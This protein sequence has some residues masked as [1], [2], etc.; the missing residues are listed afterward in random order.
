MDAVGN[1]SLHLVTSVGLQSD[2][3]N[4]NPFEPPQKNK[5]QANPYLLAGN[6]GGKSEGLFK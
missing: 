6:F 2:L 5:V 4:R 1:P 3:I